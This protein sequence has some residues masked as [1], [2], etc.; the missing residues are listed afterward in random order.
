MM[1]ATA[2]GDAGG[3][4]CIVGIGTALPDA[5]TRQSDAGDRL[6]R[7]WNLTGDDATRWTRIVESSGI[8]RRHFAIDPYVSATWTTGERMQA[9]E[10]EAPGLA[11]AAARSAMES[12]GVGVEAITDLIIVSCTGFS[13]PGVDVA[14]VDQLGLRNDVRRT[15]VGFMGCFGAITG[16]RAGVGAV[17]ATRGSVALVVCIE[18]CTLHLRCDADP[19]NQVASALFGDGAAAAIVAE[20][21]GTGGRDEFAQ[22]GIGGSRLSRQGRERMT[23]RITDHGFA[24]TLAPT[25]PSSLRRAACGLVSRFVNPGHAA[26]L[27]H[28]GGPRVLDAVEDGLDLTRGRLTHSRDVLHRCGN[29]SSPTVLFVLDAALR[30]GVEGA[31]V[32]MAFGPGLTIEV[33]PAYL[34]ARRTDRTPARRPVEYTPSLGANGDKSRR[35]SR[36]RKT[37]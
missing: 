6:A 22:V 31:A 14:L 21:S 25:V 7:L 34:N 19:Q 33:M 4:A 35:V 9:Y 8:D 5:W 15:T 29:M 27:V 10:R 18:L 13:A 17:A 30:S 26:L 28:P 1:H 36:E 12:S 37:Q 3:G 24:M 20:T 2:N 32:L 11:V 16:L 23:W